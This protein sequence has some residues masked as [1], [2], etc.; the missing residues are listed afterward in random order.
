MANDKKQFTIEKIEKLLDKHEIPEA[1]SIYHEIGA[2]PHEKIEKKQ[3]EY[4]EYLK[5]LKN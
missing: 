5:S 4:E 3:R 1:I 2:K